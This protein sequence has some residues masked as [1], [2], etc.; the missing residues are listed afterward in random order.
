MND[1]GR[2]ATPGIATDA[3]V[4]ASIEV[5]ERRAGYTVVRAPDAP[6]YW[7]ANC[8]VLDVAPRPD[9]YEAW[10][11][12]CAACF[13]GSAVQRRIVVWETS[14][15]TG[16]PFH[17]GPIERECTTIF[18]STSAPDRRTSAQ[19]RPLLSDDDWARALQLL[20][21]DLAAEG[22]M[23][24]SE[25]ESWRFGIYRRDAAAHR[26]RA[27][28]AWLDGRLVAYAGLY[29][30]AELARFFT[31]VTDPAYRR[32]GLFGALAAIGMR[33]VLDRH[34]HATIVVGA[35]KGAFTER[36]YAR[37]GFRATAE[38]HA[39]VAPMVRAGA[40]DSPSHES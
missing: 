27:W 21:A 6:G 31:P 34:P 18:T 15:R 24:R 13:A 26:C 36:V 40:D 19:I 8:L 22:N 17:D 2:I 23:S 1:R 5:R 28:G 20:I 11:A 32:R 12:E 10:L 7:F 39:L 9:S 33:H 38:Q 4:R 14:E 16:R 35:E 25:F 30:N 37:L 3:L 29:F